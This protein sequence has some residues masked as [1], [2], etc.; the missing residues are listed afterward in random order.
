MK[1]YY[2]PGVCSLAPHILLREAGIDFTLEKV[3]AA[4]KVTESGQDFRAIN[5]NGY[6]PVLELEPGVMLTEGPAIMQYIADR[7]PQAKLAPVAGS[8]ERYRLQS[9]LNFITAEIHKGFSPLFK[10]DTL[11][12]TKTAVKEQLAKRFDFVEQH[13]SRHDTLL[14]SGFSAA[15]AYLFVTTGW[16]SYVGIELKRWPA[17]IAFRKRVEQ[18]P[19]VRTALIAEGLLK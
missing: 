17:I 9:W 8:L 5:P 3:D 11:A 16:S 13:L 4:T 12:E 6:V 7:A 18:R 19:A 1:L 2:S 15:D 14:D 10:P